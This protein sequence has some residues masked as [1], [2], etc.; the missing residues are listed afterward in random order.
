MA[1][2][3]PITHL[4]RLDP[5]CEI[6]RH[7]L[8]AP[9]VYPGGVRRDLILDRV[10][11]DDSPGVTVLQGPAGHGKST[12]L[13]QI[14]AAHEARGWRTAWLT[15]DDADNDPRRFEAHFGKLLASLTSPV[16]PDRL[17]APAKPQY[18]SEPRDLA[19]AILDRL[20]HTGAPVAI[21]L[22]E[23]Q[24]LADDGI[25]RFFRSLLAR[26]PAH[27]RVFIGSRTPP[28]VGLAT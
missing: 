25:L 1:F 24:T 11:L 6:R 21:M 16:S 13:Q 2:F 18:G 20:G 10:L 23:F 19:D 5:P 27:V 28:D 17:N 26:L 4:D 14:K 15:L 7:K 9:P 12:T 8:F 22:D 3:K